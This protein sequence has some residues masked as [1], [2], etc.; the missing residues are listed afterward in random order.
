MQ[1]TGWCVICCLFLLS[2]GSNVFLLV[3]YAEMMSQTEWP[4]VDVDTVFLAGILDAE[5]IVNVTMR[6]QGPSRP[7]YSEGELQELNAEVALLGE[8]GHARL[9]RATLKNSLKWR[10]DEQGKTILFD[11][12][13]TKQMPKT[14]FQ[15]ETLCTNG[16]TKI[17]LV[18]SDYKLSHS[19]KRISS[20]F[21]RDV[22][23]Y[24]E[25]S[26]SSLAEHGHR[27][28]NRL[29]NPFQARSQVAP[30]GEPD[31]AKDG[32]SV[33]KMRAAFSFDDVP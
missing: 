26:A 23:A 12:N 13:F 19:I 27:H 3:A 16:Q 32:K 21:T 20:G 1:V 30:D 25:L 22:S 11:M 6:L 4:Y 8:T 14:S 31:L 29:M 15:D 24:C 18:V 17:R 28:M 9:G 33:V 7:S 5:L 10:M 2:L